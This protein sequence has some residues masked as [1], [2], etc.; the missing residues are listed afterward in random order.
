M[1]N[2]LKSLSA[3]DVDEH[4]LLTDSHIEVLEHDDHYE[5]IGNLGFNMDYLFSLTC[6]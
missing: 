5:I 3:D 2:T 6:T 4:K 1:V